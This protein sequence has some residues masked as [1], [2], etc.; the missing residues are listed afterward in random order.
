[1]S[2]PCILCSGLLK[3]TPVVDGIVIV[4]QNEK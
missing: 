2:L 1:M 3:K 4:I